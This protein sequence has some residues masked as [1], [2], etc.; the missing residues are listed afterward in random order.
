MRSCSV[1]C[2][3]ASASASLPQRA[4][5]VAKLPQRLLAAAPELSQGQAVD[6][7]RVAEALRK[8]G[9]LGKNASSI[10]WLGRFPEAFELTPTSKP[11]K[12]RLRP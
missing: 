12:V 11:N 7:N 3:A 4:A 8:L 10:R 9:L 6:L 1:S 5:S 2:R